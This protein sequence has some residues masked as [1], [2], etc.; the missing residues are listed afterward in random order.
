MKKP[1]TAQCPSVAKERRPGGRHST[2]L[3][4]MDNGSWS[5]QNRERQMPLPVVTAYFDCPIIRCYMYPKVLYSDNSDSFY[6]PRIG[7]PRC[8]LFWRCAKPVPL[9]I[10]DTAAL[11]FPSGAEYRPAWH[12]GHQSRCPRAMCGGFLRSMELPALR[13]KSHF[14][15][16]CLLRQHLACLLRQHLACLLRQYRTSG[17]P[18]FAGCVAVPLQYPEYVFV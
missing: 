10:Q 6:I 14:P 5:A 3:N 16:A 12:V 13:R 18:R 7:R 2:V 8:N 1:A 11:A 4:G 15:L 17:F 9:H